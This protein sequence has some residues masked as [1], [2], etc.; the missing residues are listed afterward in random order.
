MTD[1][2]PT[3]AAVEAAARAICDVQ[4]PIMRDDGA[5]VGVQRVPDNLAERCATA[6]L[7][8][9]APLMVPGWSVTWAS[10]I[11]ALPVWQALRPL[12]EASAKSLPEDQRTHLQIE[13]RH[14]NGGGGVSVLWCGGK[15]IG[16]ITILRDQFNRSVGM[17][18]TPLPAPP[19]D[20]P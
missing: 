9:A 15:V 5:C 13:D 14:L 1:H 8:A 6:A 12:L 10:D 2:T 4:I 19:E 11:N 20:T 7:R 18:V 17:C 3:P 16:V